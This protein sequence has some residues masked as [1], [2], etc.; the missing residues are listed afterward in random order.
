VDLQNS[1]RSAFLRL[2]TF[3]VV[4]AKAKRYRFKRWLLVYLKWNL[5]R[6]ITPV[7]V[8]YLHAIEI[9]G[10]EDDERGLEL[11][12]PDAARACAVQFLEQ[13]QHHP[14]IALCPGARHF[15]K[16]WPKECWIELG[17]ELQDE[18]MAVVIFGDGSEN[19][20]VNEIAS[21]IPSAIPV[22]NRSIPEVAAIMEQCEAVVS[23]DS[24]LMH[25]AAGVGTPVVGIFGPTVEAFGFFP[26]RARS[27]VVEQNLRC[28]PCSAM[29][30]AVCK[31]GHFRCLLDTTPR[32][33]ADAVNRVRSVREQLP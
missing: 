6:K 7:P 23:N 33:V 15:T 28:R 25:V 4:W 9:L 2:F 30:T 31:E 26:F 14:A 16:R 20:L 24:G 10:A 13:T 3:P 27:E 11:R 8:R 32:M 17:R 5:Y 1:A 21:S 19:Q 12:V 29:G 18:G 22:V